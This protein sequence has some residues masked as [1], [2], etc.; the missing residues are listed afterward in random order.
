[1]ASN[2]ILKV[3]SGLVVLAIIAMVVV[4]KSEHL[5]WET[6][7]ND[8]KRLVEQ[9]V[10]KDNPTDDS[11]PPEGQ[12]EVSG[13]SSENAEANSPKDG[14]D[15]EQSADTQPDSAGTDAVNSSRLVTGVMG[16][17]PGI[18]QIHSIAEVPWQDAQINRAFNQS[19]DFACQLLLPETA[20]KPPLTRLPLGR[21]GVMGRM[22]AVT[23]GLEIDSAADLK[24]PK[25]SAG[26]IRSYL[27]EHR[28]AIEPIVFQNE[29]GAAYFGTDC[30]AAF[31]ENAYPISTIKA[32][33]LIEEAIGKF[34]AI[35]VLRESKDA[36][37]RTLVM[38]F[39]YVDSTQMTSLTGSKPR[40]VTELLFLHLAESSTD[41]L[42]RLEV[43]ATTDSRENLHRLSTDTDSVI[44]D[45]LPT[46]AASI[47]FDNFVLMGLY[48]AKPVVTGIRL[49]SSGV[50]SRDTI[51]KLTGTGPENDRITFQSLLDQFAT[52]TNG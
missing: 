6:I 47:R 28:L 27:V 29:H 32:E 44:Q 2:S 49:R 50:I 20:V 30:R 3:L 26:A 43:F 19:K 39:R 18:E 15:D 21:R 1:M 11:V 33:A 9:G 45:P 7:F 10:P 17:T 41:K 4:E 51:M 16:S 12:K 52:I 34:R 37:G 46:I 35:G 8:L 31:Y 38:A 40:D 48:P 36:D 25:A 42:P 14:T 23:L 24:L 22:A 13:A 5:S